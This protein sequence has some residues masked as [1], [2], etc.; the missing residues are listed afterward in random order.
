MHATQSEQQISSSAPIQ[1]ERLGT[2]AQ[3]SL[4]TLHTH[5]CEHQP[6]TPA[7]AASDHRPLPLLPPHGPPHSPVLPLPHLK[8]V[9]P[10]QLVPSLLLLKAGCHR[11]WEV[12][13]CTVLWRK[14]MIRCSC[15]QPGSSDLGYVRWVHP[16]EPTAP[17]S[18]P[19]HR[20][21]RPAV[22]RP[23]RG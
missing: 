5:R 15:C 9:T 12:Q 1:F 23:C 19:A 4:A 17:P 20:R 22:L 3:H 13:L 2:N 16:G 6:V 18:P 21:G 8:D 7:Q 10:R 14:G 11:L